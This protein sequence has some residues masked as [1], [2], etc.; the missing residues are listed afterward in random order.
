[1]NNKLTDR[2]GEDHPA[3]CIQSSPWLGVELYLSCI[4]PLWVS[5]CQRSVF[6]E[7]SLAPIWAL[8]SLERTPAF[9]R[10]DPWWSSPSA[11]FWCRYF[12]NPEIWPILHLQEQ[13]L[14]D[15][16]QS[17]Q[18]LWT[19]RNAADWDS[20]IS[21]SNAADCCAA[22]SLS[23]PCP[24]DSCYHYEYLE[25]Q[26][27]NSKSSQ[28]SLLTNSCT[29][30]L[31]S[32][33]QANSLLSLAFDL[34]RHWAHPIGSSWWPFCWKSWSLIAVAASSSWAGWTLTRPSWADVELLKLPAAGASTSFG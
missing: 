25:L 23:P 14:I 12:P 21:T 34:E 3:Y 18:L 29:V 28:Y 16:F 1:M 26:I 7:V 10:V 27:Q 33:F 5:S 32:T 31:D 30:A 8:D 20:P 9:C 22:D 19:S 6:A 17:Y 2:P 11:A 15:P 4:W 24:R 13:F